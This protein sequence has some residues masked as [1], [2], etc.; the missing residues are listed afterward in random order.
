LATRGKNQQ[1][2]HVGKKLLDKA[3]LQRAR[4]GVRALQAQVQ[5][6]RS[7]R[8]NV[9]QNFVGGTLFDG[10]KGRNDLRNPAWE[11]SVMAR[12]GH[13]LDQ[14]RPIIGERTLKQDDVGLICQPVRR[15]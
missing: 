10:S 1:I 6:V 3:Q 13:Q 8:E 9:T 5:N 11:F 2:L 4:T 14:R 15:K 12:S 7:Q